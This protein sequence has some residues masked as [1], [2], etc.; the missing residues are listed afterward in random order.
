MRF[1]R[2]K[3]GGDVLTEDE[4]RKQWRDDYD[5]GD[6]TNLLSFYDQYE[7]VKGREAVLADIDHVIATHAPADKFKYQ[8]LDRLRC[9]C[10]YF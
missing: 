5:G 7:E 10:D 6:P 4:A 2:N 3:D 1:Y 9:D 8:L